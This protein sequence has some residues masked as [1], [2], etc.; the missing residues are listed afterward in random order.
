MVRHATQSGGKFIIVLLTVCTAGLYLPALPAASQPLPGAYTYAVVVSKAAYA[1]AGWKAVVDSLVSKHAGNS[2]RLFTWTSSVQEVKA[3]LAAF[4]PTYAGFVARPAVECNASF[5]VAISQL[6]RTLDSDPYG[7]AV[8]GVVTGFTASDALRAISESVA[9]KTVIMGSND[10]NYEPP[11]MRFYQG[12]GMPCESY[13]KTDYLFPNTGGKV[14]NV[15]ARPNGANDRTGLICGWLNATTLNISV[16][17]QGTITGPFD[18]LIT[19]GH[20][21]VNVWQMHYSDVGTEGYIMSSNGQLYGSPYSGATVNVNAPTPKVFWCLSNCLMG[22]PDNANDFVYAAF[23]TG[24]AVQMFGFVPDAHAGDDFMSWGMY[25]RIT[26]FAGMYTLPQGFFISQNASQFEILHSTGQFS[27]ADVKGY[28]D[29]S[30]MYGD[31]AANV[32]FADFGDS[33]KP[34]VENMTYTANSTGKAT[35]VLTVKTFMQ[36]VGF[37]AG[38]CYAFRPVCLLPARID[39]STVAIVKNDGHTA[40]ITDNLVVWELLSKGE[41]MQAASTRTL[42]WTAALVSPTRAAPL[43]AHNRPSP[44]ARIHACRARNGVAVLFVLSDLAAGPFDLTIVNTAGKLIYKGSHISS[45]S[46]RQT[47]AA[48]VRCGQEACCAIVRGRGVELR[49]IIAGPL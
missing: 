16:A 20:G 21:N 10:I 36:S 14:Y 8:W 35:F 4:M 17:G 9:V 13:T 47:V 19:G 28:L 27:L 31:P 29:S 46:P 3:D 2:A 40:D 18:C 32:T 15:E 38:Y 42:S 5:I 1:D 48:P 44:K 23:H 41:T 24:H 11:L 12:I 30:A 6:C 37:G 43:T 22:C 49:E 25:D 39:P 45:G 26:K 7:D 34:Y 33:A